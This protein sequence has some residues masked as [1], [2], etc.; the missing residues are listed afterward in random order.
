MANGSSAYYNSVIQHHQAQSSHANSQSYFGHVAGGR[1]STNPR[2]G[3]K[4]QHHQQQQQQHEVSARWTKAKVQVNV[5]NCDFFVDFSHWW[6]AINWRSVAL[7]LDRGPVVY[8]IE[9]MRMVFKPVWI[10]QRLRLLHRAMQLRLT[11]CDIQLVHAKHGSQW[12]PGCSA[13]LAINM[14][15]RWAAPFH[16]T[17]TVIIKS[18]VNVIAIAIVRMVRNDMLM[19][20]VSKMAME[21][22]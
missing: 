2:Y 3:N 9:T 15:R 4:N 6:A 14:L 13:L 7:W 21:S 8:L 11:L 5:K 16:E 17:H 10:G 1:G 20:T 22:I 12:I 19:R 18:I